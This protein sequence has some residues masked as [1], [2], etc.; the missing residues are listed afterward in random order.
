MVDSDYIFESG[1]AIDVGNPVENDY[2][3]ES[4]ND[5]SDSD[6]S[7][8]VF[9]S[10]R[11]LGGEVVIEDFE[12]CNL[13]PYQADQDLASGGEGMK[14]VNSPVY[15]GSCGFE[16]EFNNTGIWTDQL[17]PTI[18]RGDTF[19]FVCRIDTIGFGLEFGFAHTSAYHQGPGYQVGL[20][21]NSYG[22]GLML[23]K[24]SGAI[25]VVDTGKPLSEW[26]IVECSFG[27]PTIT[28]KAYDP[29]DGTELATISFDDTSADGNYIG[30]DSTNST[31]GGFAYA[32]IVRL[33]PY[34]N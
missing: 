27:D 15:E 22:T 21:G 11:G 2:V 32:D 10:D 30:W 18:D 34:N 1:E 9:I 13:D 29:N 26:I 8:F 12:R 23:S 4:N 19:H 7:N 6:K 5:I 24:E 17:T 3:K 28:A 25:D 33:T 31:T 16:S 14:I 20:R